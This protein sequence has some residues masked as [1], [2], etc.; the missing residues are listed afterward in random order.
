MRRLGAVAAG[1]TLVVLSASSASADH[2]ADRLEVEAMLSRAAAEVEAEIAALDDNAPLPPE[3][4][5]ARLE[6][7]VDELSRRIF[8]VR[9]EARRAVAVFHP[10]I[11]AEHAEAA[12]RVPGVAMGLDDAADLVDLEAIL[13]DWLRLEA[14]LDRLTAARDELAAAAGVDP[15]QRRCPVSGGQEFADG[16]GD[17][18]GWGRSHKGIDL[19]AEFGTPLVAVEDGVVVQ[20]GWHWAGGVQAYLLGDASGDV[21]YYAHMTWWAPGIVPGAAVSAGDPIGWVGM[22]GNASSPH[23]HFGWMPGAGG[24]DLGGLEN[25]YWLLRELC[26]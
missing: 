5:V 20:A 25:P 7:R 9:Y 17:D 6:A 19:H 3:A 24:V 11:D 18:R 15:L 4:R 16:W 12:R 1:M 8:A 21:Y 14:A 26:G 22:S 23:L 13:G 2:G 10:G